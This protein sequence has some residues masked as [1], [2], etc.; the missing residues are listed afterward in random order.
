[1]QVQVNFN[2]AKNR[3]YPEQVAIV[4]ARDGAGKYNPITLCWIMYTSFK[5]PMLAVSVGKTRYS[6]DVIRRA[7]E[8]VV[9]YPSTAMAETALYFGT[10]SGDQEDK[11]AVSGVKTEP[12]GRIDGVLLSEAVANFE[13]RLVSEHGSGDHVIFVGEVVAAHVNADRNL[14]RLYVIGPNHQMGSARPESIG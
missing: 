14:A 11:L 1:M 8:F 5:P 3:K 7:G 12:A 6:L 2:E 13:C 10:A 9:S 4:I